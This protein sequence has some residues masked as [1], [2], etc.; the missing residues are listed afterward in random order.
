MQATDDLQN[1][2]Y[3][4]LLNF[5]SRVYYVISMKK[6]DEIQKPHSSRIKIKPTFGIGLR[7][8]EQTALCALLY[9]KVSVIMRA[10]A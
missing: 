3:K 4:F 5:V 7:V 9:L 10:P 1:T 6:P 8:G 2:Q